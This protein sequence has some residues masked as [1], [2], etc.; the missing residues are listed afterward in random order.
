[1]LRDVKLRYKQTLLGVIW[2]ILQPLVAAGIFTLIFGLFADLPSGSVEYLPFVF[3]GLLMWN[4]FS[5]ALQRAGN[6]LLSDSRLISKVYFPRIVLP[7]A[8]ACAV[9]VDFA[10]A[11]VV[12]FVLLMVSGIP[13]TWQ[14]LTLPLWVALVL[15]IGI[16]VSLFISSLNVYYRDFSYALPFL[17][18]VWMYASPVVYSPELIPDALKP[19]YALNPM[20][21]V[22]EGF[23]W[24]VLGQTEFPLIPVLLAFGIGIV[25]FISGAFVFYR[26]ENNFADVI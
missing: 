6:S 22:I 21:G 4:I 18:Q 3:S 19:V 1:M 12:M 24:A 5:G 23:R 17:V 13:L 10:V 20:V 8:S 7:I 26:V 2:V 16:G 11:L 25:L 9:L 15:L 14:M